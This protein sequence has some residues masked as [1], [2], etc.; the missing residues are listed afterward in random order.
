MTPIRHL[1]ESTRKDDK[2]AC[3]KSQPQGL[4]PCPRESWP[5]G[6]PSR[7]ARVW[8]VSSDSRASS[9]LPKQPQPPPL[10]LFL[11]QLR[12]GDKPGPQ[13]AW[14]A[15]LQCVFITASYITLCLPRGQPPQCPRQQWHCPRPLLCPSL[16]PGKRGWPKTQALDQTDLVSNAGSGVPP[17]TEEPSSLS[18][19][20]CNQ[21]VPVPTGV[22]AGCGQGITP[23]G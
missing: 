14:V 20:T 8:E 12:A 13:G 17:W 2:A 7:P 3:S 9:L 19:L 18:F 15:V 6:A 21:A 16:M 5:A 22:G 10:S 1:T 11:N 4:E 23:H